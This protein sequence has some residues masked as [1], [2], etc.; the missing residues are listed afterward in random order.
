MPFPA[1][2]TAAGS[3]PP[4]VT[5]P[6]LRLAPFV[7]PTQKN[8]MS[9]STGSRVKMSMRKDEEIFTMLAIETLSSFSGS[10]AFSG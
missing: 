7:R 9:G 8:T 3:M 4:S 10:Q 6:A 2:A 5:A 1:S